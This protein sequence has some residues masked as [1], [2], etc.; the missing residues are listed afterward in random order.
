MCVG[1]VERPD[2][3]PAFDLAWLG[4]N[5]G[6]GVLAAPVR[7]GV[8]GGGYSPLPLCWCAAGRG[9]VSRFTVGG[10]TGA[11]GFGR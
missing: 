6:A 3:L 4:I 10:G 5:W 8:Q 11:A 1:V 7:M 2:P 9:E